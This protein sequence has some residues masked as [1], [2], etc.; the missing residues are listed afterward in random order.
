MQPLTNKIYAE[1]CKSY[2]Q[3]GSK[4]YDEMLLSSKLIIQDVLP[5]DSAS[6]TGYTL[7]ALNMSVKYDSRE[8]L[9]GNSEG[10]FLNF[11]FEKG[12]SILGF[13]LGGIDYKKGKRSMLLSIENR[14]DRYKH[15]KDLNI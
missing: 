4:L 14:D 5:V 11:S 6:F 13:N 10:H 12:G 15:L 1:V 9:S 7:N 2:E 8:D 3:Y